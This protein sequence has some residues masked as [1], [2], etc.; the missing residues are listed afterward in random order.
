MFG[1]GIFLGSLGRS[2]LFALLCVVP[3]V[4]LG[5]LVAELLHTRRTVQRFLIPLF[6]LPV[7]LPTVVV[8]LYWRIML[9]G[10]FGLAS[11]YLSEWGLPFAQALLSAPETILFTLAAIDVWQWGPFVALVF[12]AKRGTLPE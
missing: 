8:G 5:I 1:D 11:H 12:L 3:Q 2:C 4:V 9:Q 7:L 6:A 10:E